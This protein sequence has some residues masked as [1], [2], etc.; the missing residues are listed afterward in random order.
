MEKGVGAKVWVNR[1]VAFLAG[2]LLVLIV[3]S[4]AVVSPAKTENAALKTKLDDVQ[5]G[6]SRLLTEAKTL[7]EAKNY[8][9]AQRVLLSLLEK[10]PGSTEA[11]EGK[12]LSAAIDATVKEMD[13]KWEAVSGA[14]RVEW[15]AKAAKDLR[16][17]TEE[18]RLQQEKDMSAT[19]TA[20]WD[21]AKD[22]VRLAWEN[23]RK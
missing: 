11:A 19:L 8:G 13:S 9:S 4:A 5:N 10:Q 17:K 6:A 2:G 23:T 16:A 21:K 18:A 15:E 7:A 20:G 12:K 3:M 1:V 22:D 14:L